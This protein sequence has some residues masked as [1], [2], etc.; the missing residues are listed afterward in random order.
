M[1]K[2]GAKKAALDFEPEIVVMYCQNCVKKD[3]KLMDA[4]RKT[5]GA[6]AKLIVMPCSSKI[7][8]GHMVRILELGADGIEV[9]TCPPEACRMLGGATKEKA[10]VQYVKDR[11]AEIGF[12]PDRVGLTRG[13]GLSMDD[14]L[15]I[16]GKRATAVA[17][18]GPSP[19]KKK[20]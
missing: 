2:K 19:M 12:G 20:D 18:V 17:E 3:V 14:L 6:K 16:A 1:T 13:S 5:G 7:E 8:I 11:L 9:V 10:R 15:D 4:V